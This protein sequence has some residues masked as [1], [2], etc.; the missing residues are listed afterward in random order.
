MAKFDRSKFQAAKVADLQKQKQEAE[1]LRPKNNNT[2]PGYINLEKGDNVVRWYPPHPNTL[3][4]IYQKCISWL[5]FNIETTDDKGKKKVELKK[6]PVF[7]ARIHAGTPKD[8]VEEY[9]AA[10]KRIIQRDETDASEIKK[11]IDSLYNWKTG[12]NP[13]YS[14]VGYAN[15]KNSKGTSFGRLEVK[16]SIKYKQD[17]LGMSEDSDEPMQVDPF[18]DPDTGRLVKIVYN[19]G[20][21]VKPQDVYKVSFVTKD[22]VPISA[23]LS[24]SDLEK[25]AEMDSLESLFVNSYTSKDFEKAIEGLELY[26]QQNALGV[27]ADDDFLNVCEELAALYPDAPE[28][29]DSDDT[30]DNGLPFEK[31]GQPKADHPVNQS[32]GKDD[33]WIKEMQQDE[34]E[35]EVEKVAVEADPVQNYPSKNLSPDEMKQKLAALKAKMNKGR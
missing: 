10:A 5:P 34:S 13:V 6:R 23:P 35:P 25:F 8:I 2:R 4:Y 29:K 20:D 1:A 33:R 22:F 7:N 19:T 11:K 32:N 16:P 15:V 26:D 31:G 12:I 14:W 28:S 17:E 24:D 27:F 21:D 3:S 9:I 18:T 30:D